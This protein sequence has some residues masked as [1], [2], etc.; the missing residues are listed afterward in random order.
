MESNITIIN[1]LQGVIANC[2]SDLFDPSERFALLDFPNH[3]NIGDS[4]IWLG[5]L[6]YFDKKRTR[7]TYVTEIPTYDEDRMLGAI[8]S[9]RIFLHG[10]GNFGDIWAGYRQFREGLLDKH[11]GR[12]IVQMPQTIH[13]ALLFLSRTI[14][15]RKFPSTRNDA[16]RS[17]CENP[18][19]NFDTGNP[20]ANRK[21]PESKRTGCR[22]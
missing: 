12:P 11:K 10:G 16:A 2:L 4:A 3:Y 21:S 7:P 6:A 22:T 19:R 17:T 18:V 5:E 15:S 13:A 9:G 1:R 8:S 20:A 14:L